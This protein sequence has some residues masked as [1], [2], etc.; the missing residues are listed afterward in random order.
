[1]QII[2]LQELQFKN[3]SHIHSA[4]NIY[5]TVEYAKVLEKKGYTKSYLGLINENNS[6]VAA[7]LLMTKKLNKK[8]F[9]GYV[10]RGFLIDYQNSEL[11]RTFTENLKAYL[12]EKKYIFI[13][14]DPLIIYKK[15]NKQN[16]VI[17]ENKNIMPFLKTLG[18]N[19]LGFHNYFEAH[20]SRYYVYLNTQNKSIEEMYQNISRNVKRSIQ[21]S[22]NM[23]ITIHQG[24]M[25][26]I[27]LFYSLIQ[28]KT[29]IP[30]E[31]F[32]DYLSYFNEKENKFEIYFAKIDPEIYINNYRYLERQELEKN[33]QLYQKIVQSNTKNRKLINKK[34]VSDK[35][36]QKYKKEV[37]NATKIYSKF[38]N[39]LIVGTCAIF[40]NNRQITFFMDG[41]EEKLREVHSSYIL[42]WEIIKKY[43][44]EGF[45]I[46]NLGEISGNRDQKNNKYYG[47][48]FSKMGFHGEVIEYP[49]EFDLIIHPTLYSIFYNIMHL[50]SKKKKKS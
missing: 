46:F 4:R 30:I 41:Y 39:G 36:L 8:Y 28:K 7:C 31:E 3:Y 2:E 17:Y 11:L 15:Y 47:L 21:N 42:K 49:G 45:Q 1:M 5:Q 32:K 35:I 44:K 48:Y 50:K 40:K 18:Y 16:E 38:P 26:N 43:M 27:D 14:L 9:Y 25:E 33:N 23:G 6:L 34:L 29:T 24:T 20:N 12:K 19:H 13:K 22:L 37:I 10:P